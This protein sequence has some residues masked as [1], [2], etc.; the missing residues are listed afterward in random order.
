VWHWQAVWFTRMGRHECLKGQAGR[1]R[2]KRTPRAQACEGCD[3]Q[4]AG[5]SVPLRQDAR[6]QM[7]DDARTQAVSP[8]PSARTPPAARPPKRREHARLGNAWKLPLCGGLRR[9]WASGR[10]ASV[11]T[12]RRHPE[13]A[14]EPPSTPGGSQGAREPGHQDQG[15]RAATLFP[16]T[17]HGCVRR[18]IYP[19]S[20]NTSPLQQVGQYNRHLEQLGGIWSVYCC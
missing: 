19:H 4:E 1:A 14:R 2:I 9:V 17:L 11:A 7:Q 8:S 13:D 20:W 15:T 12:K 5:R 18:P 3:V 10:A 6:R 16:P